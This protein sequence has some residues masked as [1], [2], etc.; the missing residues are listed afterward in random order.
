[1]TINQTMIE[2]NNP[3]LAGFY[4]YFFYIAYFKTIR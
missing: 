1:M 4:F 2:S 3:A